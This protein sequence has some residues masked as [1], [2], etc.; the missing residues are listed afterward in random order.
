MVLEAWSLLAIWATQL[1]ETPE[2]CMLC[3]VQAKVEMERLPGSRLANQIA[4][5]G[6]QFNIVVE[7]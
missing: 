6:R 3:F 1:L 5:S 7:P 2:A 4:R